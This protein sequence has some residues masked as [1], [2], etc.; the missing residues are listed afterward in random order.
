M[1]APTLYFV[2]LV[3]FGA[4]ASLA[5]AQG[6][7]SG[8]FEPTE[9]G[10]SGFFVAPLVSY[11]DLISFGPDAEFL[12][13]TVGFGA[14]MGYDFHDTHLLG[15]QLGVLYQKYPWK[16]DALLKAAGLVGGLPPGVDVEVSGGLEAIDVFVGAIA[17]FS[18]NRFDFHGSLGSGFVLVKED[19]EVSA[20]GL[21]VPITPGMGLETGRELLWE[22][23]VGLGAD[24]YFTDWLAAGLGFNL[25]YATDLF[26]SDSFGGSGFPD[27]L[28]YHLGGR[29]TFKF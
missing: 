6:A 5:R 20:S 12:G 2:F 4:S 9:E 3:V 18:V 25:L 1:R 22:L 14:T 29:V 10:R 17:G 13:G 21:G 15:V 28:R 26:T 19:A 7:P 16:E 8:T 27:L 11:T 24:Y 23:Q